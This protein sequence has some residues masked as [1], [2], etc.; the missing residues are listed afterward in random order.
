VYQRLIAP[1]MAVYATPATAR[2]LGAT[3]AWR[4]GT[5]SRIWMSLRHDAL[6]PGDSQSRV[7]AGLGG[8]RRWTTFAAGLTVERGTPVP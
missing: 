1:E 2:A 5:S 8:D 3:A 7:L 4:T 6:S